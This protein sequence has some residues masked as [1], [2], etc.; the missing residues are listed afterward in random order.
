MDEGPGMLLAESRRVGEHGSDTRGFTDGE[1]HVWAVWLDADEERTRGLR[2]LL[3][4]DEK[5]RADRYRFEIHR[6]RFICGRAA[7]RLLLGEYLGKEEESLVFNYEPNGKPHLPGKGEESISFNV[8]HSE[9]LQL[10]AI[11]SG[12]EIGVDVEK[13]RWLPDFEELV[14]RFF[15]KCESEEFAALQPELKAAA[16]F[17][18]WTRKEALL[19]ATGEG[20]CNWLDR[21]EVTFLPD[22]PARLLALPECAGDPA[23]WA[24]RHFK[25]AVGY[26]AA[27]A[28]K[29]DDLRVCLR[30]FLPGQRQRN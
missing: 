8:A 22:E 6:Q 27:V 15:S 12:M 10:I 16:F 26:A 13:I 4:P 2:E 29:H 24:L 11:T 28:A 23:D 25:P 21:V 7:L 14:Q 9:S 20:I 17:N 3:S 19:K 5:E 18:L 1:T 30:E